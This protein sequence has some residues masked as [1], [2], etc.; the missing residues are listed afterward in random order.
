MNDSRTAHDDRAGQPTRRQALGVLA[1][2]SAA[3]AALPALAEAAAAPPPVEP[4]ATVPLQPLPAALSVARMTVAGRPITAIMRH[5]KPGDAERCRLCPRHLCEVNSAG[6][7]LVL[8][9]Q[10][11]A[12][13][14][15]ALEPL[16]RPPQ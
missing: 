15:A 6:A 9:P 4:P 2:L 14:E 8:V 3:P 7:C 11:V 12:D 1:A 16:E 13:H 10:H 5:W